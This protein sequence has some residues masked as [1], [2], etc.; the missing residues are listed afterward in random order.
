[1]DGVTADLGA[2]GGRITVQAEDGGHVLYLTGDVDAAVVRQLEREHHLAHL[3]VVAVDV[4][5][6]TYIDS[7]ALALLVQWS[8]EAA[9]E[10]RPA[11]IRNT[12]QRFERVL[13]LAGLDELFAR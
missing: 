5:G 12:T 8:R 3:H 1:V 9:G 2:T 4:G 13:E 10:G 6:L 11:I 7:S